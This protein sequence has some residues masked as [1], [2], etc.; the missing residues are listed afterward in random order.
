MLPI[1]VLLARLAY[2]FV[3]VNQGM[4]SVLGKTM[5]VREFRPRCVTLP[6]DTPALR[7]VINWTGR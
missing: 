7:V 3:G 5:V 1:N 4:A 2:C 6:R